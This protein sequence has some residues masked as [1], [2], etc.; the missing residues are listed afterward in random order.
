MA[1]VQ[2]K[3]I[4]GF[5]AQSLLSERNVV[6]ELNM[7]KNPPSENAIRCWL[8]QFKETRSVLHRKGSGRPLIEPRKCFSRSPQK[9]TREA[10]LQLGMSETF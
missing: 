2:E 1:T 3:A 4:F 10:S 9:S 7:E 6:L 5:S 8:K